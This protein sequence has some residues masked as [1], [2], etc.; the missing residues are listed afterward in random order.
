MLR[1][2]SDVRVWKTVLFGLLVADVGHLY[3]VI[4][5][6]PEIYWNFLKWNAIDWGN[7]AF[8]YAGASFRIAFLLGLGM[9]TPAK[10]SLK[11]TNKTK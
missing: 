4:G 9:P 2:T 6:G 3:S 5:L 7:I 1:S 10:P 11:A 8:V